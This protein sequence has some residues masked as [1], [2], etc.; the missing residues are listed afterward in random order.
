M[1]HLSQQQVP[2]WALGL[3]FVASAVLPML[4]RW[5]WRALRLWMRERRTDRGEERRA[6]ETATSTIAELLRE[7][8]VEVRE[9][10]NRLEHATMV[11]V[12]LRE[13]NAKLR[14]EAVRFSAELASVREQCARLEAALVAKDV[15]I[16]ELRTA[17]ANE[18]VEAVRREMGG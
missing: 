13:E 14:A 10:G 11:A 8:R 18:L 15:V 4:L 12:G 17:S 16:A 1:E 9:L 6:E 5:A 7:S 3:T 2:M